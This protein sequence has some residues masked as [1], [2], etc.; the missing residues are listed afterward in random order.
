MF[1]KL[2]IRNRMKLRKQKLEFINAMK[3]MMFT[4][5]VLQIGGNG[6]YTEVVEELAEIKKQ[7][8]AAKTLEELAIPAERYMTLMKEFGYEE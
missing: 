4:F 3:M 1:N 5:S 8:E 7:A 2:S 6:E